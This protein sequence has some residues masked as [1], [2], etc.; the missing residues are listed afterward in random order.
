[1]VDF[2]IG[3]FDQF[4][5]AAQAGY[6]LF[7]ALVGFVVKDNSLI[8]VIDHLLVPLQPVGDIDITEYA[9][10]QQLV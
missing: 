10:G 3:A 6:L 2:P 9:L 4:A 7:D 1:M 5:I 8:R